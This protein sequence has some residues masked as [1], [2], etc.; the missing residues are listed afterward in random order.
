MNNELKRLRKIRGIT[1]ADMAGKVGVKLATYGTWERGERMLSASQL[2][3]CAE[4]LGCSTDAIL[5][6]EVPHDFD[7]PMEAALHATWENL[8]ELR[9]SGVLKYAQEQLALQQMGGAV[10]RPSRVDAGNEVRT[11]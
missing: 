10:E 11:A 9:R 4:I 6:H 8:D 7:D 5:G 3:Q 1:Q 2:L